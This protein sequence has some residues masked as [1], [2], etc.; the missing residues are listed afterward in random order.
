MKRPSKTAKPKAHTVNPEWTD[1]M[2]RK[3]RP[4]SAVL[5]ELFGQEQA[6]KMLSPRGRPVVGEAEHCHA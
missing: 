6:A 2:F 1:A 4:A 5:P 3:A